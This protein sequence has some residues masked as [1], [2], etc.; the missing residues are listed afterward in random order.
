MNALDVAIVSIAAATGGAGLALIIG[1]FWLCRRLDRALRPAGQPI[2]PRGTADRLRAVR[3]LAQRESD[4]R[5]YVDGDHERVQ[6]IIEGI[7]HGVILLA[8][9]GEIRSANS[10]GARFIR[11]SHGEAL[12][13]SAV[14]AM[15]K[16]MPTVEARR[17]VELGGHPTQAYQIVLRPLRHRGTSLAL[18]EDVSARHRLEAVRRDFV[19]NISHE[20]KTPVGAIALLT[21]TLLD[22]HDPDVIFSV[23]RRLNVEAVRLG[24]TIDDLLLLSRIE[25][26]ANTVHEP[27]TV[28]DALSE[29]R[30]RLVIAAED[31]S[32]EVKYDP[33]PESLQVV[34]DR[35]QLVSAVFNLLDNALKYSEPGSIVELRAKRERNDVVIAVEDHGIGVPAQDRD[36]IFERFYRVDRARSR[37]TGGT[38]LGLAIVRHVADNHGGQ[39]RVESV[40]GQG[41]TFVLTVPV[42]ARTAL[43]SALEESSS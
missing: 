32:I 40:E 37:H 18:I 30:E 13:E 23:S 33:P 41:S 27:V 8:S 21:E 1:R 43:P 42:G 11:A 2:E 4:A 14:L 36:R 6:A 28:A 3:Q 9:N 7:P 39:V 22:E 10:A 15:A 19:A 17:L 29:A 26:E 24:H 5:A 25:G 38:G 35:R 31:R 34:G 20:L 12:V 16:E